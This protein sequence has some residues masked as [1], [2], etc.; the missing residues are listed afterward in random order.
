MGKSSLP[1]VRF[2]REP[3]LG[4]VRLVPSR[5]P[6]PWTGISPCSLAVIYVEYA[7]WLQNLET[8][9]ILIIFHE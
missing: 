4:Q 8:G 5:G 1:L 2:L 6:W 7:K 9:V 3:L